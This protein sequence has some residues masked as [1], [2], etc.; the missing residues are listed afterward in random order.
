MARPVNRQIR[1]EILRIL[2]ET[3][4]T[5]MSPN[6]ITHKLNQPGL[7]RDTVRQRLLRMVAAGEVKR[8]ILGYY[9]AADA[10][11]QPIE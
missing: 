2:A 3:P 1:E 10:T 6:Y 8:P 9:Q 5:L 11:P 4:G 7:N